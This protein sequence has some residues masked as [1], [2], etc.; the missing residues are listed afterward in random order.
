MSKG[1][2]LFATKGS[3]V[4]FYLVHYSRLKGEFLSFAFVHLIKLISPLFNLDNCF[5]Q[6]ANLFCCALNS[7]RVVQCTIQSATIFITC[8]WFLTHSRGIV[9]LHTSHYLRAEPPMPTSNM[10]FTVWTSPSYRIP[11]TEKEYS[12]DRFFQ[13]E[14]TTSLAASYVL[15]KICLTPNTIF[16]TE[17]NQFLCMQ[18]SQLRFNHQLGKPKKDLARTK[19]ATSTGPAGLLQLEAKGYPHIQCAPF[20]CDT[21]HCLME[22][23]SNQHTLVFLQSTIFVP[24]LVS[25]RYWKSPFSNCLFPLLPPTPAL[26]I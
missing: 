10:L 2:S 26:E 19:R 12:R 5:I 24:M 16:Q 15:P 25:L 7:H 1:T 8:L 20:P 13:H 4:F 22:G 21:S 14:A 9:S 17:I 6:D 3:S 23:K 18:K 11:N